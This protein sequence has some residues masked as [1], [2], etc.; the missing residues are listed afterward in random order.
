MIYGLV[1]AKEKAVADYSDAIRLNPEYWQA[2]LNRG[3]I[4]RR[5][6]RLRQS[7]R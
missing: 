4:F 7:H 2:F 5:Q 1:G 6:G 3:Y